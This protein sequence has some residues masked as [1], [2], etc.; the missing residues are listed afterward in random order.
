MV[1]DHISRTDR[2]DKH[3]YDSKDYHEFIEHGG[4]YIIH[5]YS[6]I[7]IWIHQ[8]FSSGTYRIYI[9]HEIC[10]RDIIPRKREICL[11]KENSKKE[12][13]EK[14]YFFHTKTNYELDR[15]I[16]TKIS[17]KTKKYYPRSKY[18]FVF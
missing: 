2:H 9:D 13:Q 17:Q 8:T 7:S 4:E 1:D 11:E 6:S 3:C 16:I 10:F 18:I 5:R 15:E 12:K 14:E